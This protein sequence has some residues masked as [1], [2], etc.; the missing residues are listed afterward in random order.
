MVLLFAPLVGAIRKLFFYK[1]FSQSVS[2]QPKPFVQLT[3]L[4]RGGFQESSEV[5]ARL[6]GRWSR[7]LVALGCMSWLEAVEELRIATCLKK[8]HERSA[9]CTN[10]VWGLSIPEPEP[11]YLHFRPLEFAPHTGHIL[12]SCHYMCIARKAT[13]T[14]TKSSI[15]LKCLHRCHKGQRRW[16][17]GPRPRM[18]PFPAIFPWRP[19]FAKQLL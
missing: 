4:W 8:N 17:L 7:D 10:W 1:M 5:D 18:L 13:A 11:F 15:R 2:D 16:R 9:R 14:T 12:P 6:E 19:R 3:N